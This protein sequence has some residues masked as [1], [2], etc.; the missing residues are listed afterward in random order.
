MT[1]LSNDKDKKDFEESFETI[2]TQLQNDIS[3]L[4][5][6]QYDFDTYVK[7]EVYQHFQDCMNEEDFDTLYDTQIETLY[8]TKN[9]I[10][11]SYKKINDTFDHRNDHINHIDHLKSIPQPSQKTDEWYAFRKQHLTGSNLWKIF[12]TPS[13]RRQLIYEKLAPSEEKSSC[14]PSLNDCTPLNWGHKYE[15]LT[16]LFYEY[17]ND[18]VVEEFGCIPHGSIP[19]LAA[20]PD[21][22]VTSRKNNGRMVEIKNVVSRIITQIPKMEYY[23]QMQLQME[24]CDLD[25]CDFVETKF[26]EYE[27]EEMFRR[28]KYHI[29]KGFMIVLI[30]D[31]SLV[32]EYAPLFQNSEQ[33]ILD[34]TEKI[35][36]KYALVSPQLSN[37]GVSWYRNVYWKLVEYS[38]VYV[39]RNKQWFS[40]ALPKIEECWQ[41]IEKGMKE[42]GAYLN[43]KGKTRSRSNSNADEQGSPM[44]NEKLVGII[45]L[46]NV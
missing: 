7:N 35:Y 27:N 10:K 3:A 13:S 8:H 17:Y 26:I 25:E 43:Y 1:E 14:K 16:N 4:H 5:M 30:K 19:F 12:H 32:Y 42:E 33:N 46:N 29:P 34:F 37:N 38:C 44:L 36:E 24:V 23:I 20:S 28:D 22:I 41:E 18:V 21:G 45:D 40:E 15:P 2:M 39:P 31:N 11:R 6:H 9:W